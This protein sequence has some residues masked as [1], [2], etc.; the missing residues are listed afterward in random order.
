[1]TLHAVTLTGS[2]AT[3]SARRLGMASSQSSRVSTVLLYMLVL[4]PSQ[5]QRAHFQ[6]LSE[7]IKVNEKLH[8][9]YYKDVTLH[10]RKR[11]SKKNK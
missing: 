10:V 6:S 4:P 7:E 1:M 8:I 3:A 11:E 2:K 9:C 5:K